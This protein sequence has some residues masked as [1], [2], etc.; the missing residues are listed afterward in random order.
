MQWCDE[1]REVTSFILA[2]SFA[3]H[4][5]DPILPETHHQPAGWQLVLRIPGKP[6]FTQWRALR[7]FIAGLALQRRRRWWRRQRER[8]SAGLCA[9]RWRRVRRGLVAWRRESLPSCGAMRS[10]WSLQVSA[11]SAACRLQAVTEAIRFLRADVAC[12][13]FAATLNVVLQCVDSV[14]VACMLG[15]LSGYLPC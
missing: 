11:Y 12:D 8:S 15:A 3:D 5:Q 14:R 9:C 6:S 2:T 13:G 1:P 10:T 7:R 4:R